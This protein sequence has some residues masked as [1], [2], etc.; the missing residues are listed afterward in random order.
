MMKMIFTLLFLLISFPVMAS[1][2]QTKTSTNT[3]SEEELYIE[4][5][6]KSSYNLE[7]KR[8]KKWVKK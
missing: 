6:G 2:V 1:G 5:I 4:N 8:K 7:K 3:K